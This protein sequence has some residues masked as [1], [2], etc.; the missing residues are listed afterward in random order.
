MR[1]CRACLST[2]LDPFVDLGYQPPSN[3]FVGAGAKQYPLRVEVCADCGHGQ[4]AVDVDPTE[5]FNDQYAYFSSASP[6][7]LEDR[8]VLANRMINEFNLIPASLV[9][10]IGSNDGYYL[11]H[12]KERGIGVA[13]YEPAANVAEAARKIGIPTDTEFWS[14]STHAFGADLVNA[15]NVLAHTPDLDSFVE[16]V[17]HSLAADGVATFEFPLFS[18]LIKFNQLDT[19]Y[20]EHY[21]YISV[22]SLQTVLARH[23]LRLWRIEELA[24][25]GGSVRAFA[26]KQNAR[27]LEEASVEKALAEE[28]W[29]PDADFQRKADRVKWDLLAFLAESR[30][31]GTVVGYGAPAKATVLA[32]YAGLDKGIIEF[33]VDD[34]PAKQGK[35]IPGTNIPIH[36]FDVLAN[37]GYTPA[38]ILLFAWN[39]KEPIGAK[40]SKL[41]SHI[42]LRRPRLVTAV[43]HLDVTNL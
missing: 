10:D 17:A 36:S 21:S 39:L 20:H 11:R 23:S 13:G 24:T 19:I 37:L 15:T 22:H 5:I 7:W 12:F 32:N 34:S 4:M 14:R 25:H 33:T 41:Y 26:C 40:L 1:T 35:H 9:V 6:T 8:R 16:G 28:I 31:D 2:S 43:P 27:Y 42:G 3:D 38:Y 30:A 29:A 18:N